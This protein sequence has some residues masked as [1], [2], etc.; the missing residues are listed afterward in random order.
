MLG[1]VPLGSWYYLKKGLD[2]RKGA[3][4]DLKPKGVIQM[5]DNDLHTFKGKT[6][7][8]VL[9]FDKAKESL[10][11]IVDQF[12]DAY[13]FQLAGNFTEYKNTYTPDSLI[14]V[15]NTDQAVFALVDTAQQ[16]RNFY[17]AEKEE[18]R[19]MVEHLAI[20]LPNAKDK[21]IKMK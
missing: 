7:L 9:D 2:Y 12:S 4:E 14:Q 18:L 17:S 11:P 6:T 16:I 1:I 10:P 19:M 13:T 21:D 5:S 8:W 20:I 15:Y 3:L